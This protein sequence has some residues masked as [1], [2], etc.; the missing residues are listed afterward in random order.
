MKGIGIVGFMGTGK[1]V[2]G[3]ALASELG[4]PFFDSD[5]FIEEMTGKCINEIFDQDGES[6]FRRLEETAVRI[7]SSSPSVVAYGGGVILSPTNRRL[8]KNRMFVVLLKASPVTILQ[9]LAR[10]DT[11]PLLQEKTVQR[12]SA[13]LEERLPFYEAVKDCSIDTDGRSVKEIVRAI[14]REVSM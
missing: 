1:T 4:L 12:V 8:L 7:L 14:K 5:R 13:M 3:R 10:D 9:R 11:R 6:H 2:V